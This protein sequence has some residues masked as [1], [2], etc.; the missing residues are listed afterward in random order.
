MCPDRDLVPHSTAHY[1][2]A[3]FFTC[4]LC[5]ESFEG[6]GCGVFVED[7]VGE[8]GGGD[9]GEHAGVGGGDCVAA[10]VEGGGRG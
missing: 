7:V 10:E 5:H 3:S 9:G 8:G 2:Q 4:E 1:E 6:V